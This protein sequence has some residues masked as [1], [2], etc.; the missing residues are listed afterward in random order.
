MVSVRPQQLVGRLTVDV[1]ILERSGITELEVL[2]LQNSRQK[3]SGR[4]EGE[5][6]FWPYTHVLQ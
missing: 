5:C 1:T 3:G 4:A 2:P 6:T